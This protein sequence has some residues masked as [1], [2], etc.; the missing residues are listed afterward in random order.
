MCYNL[1]YKLIETWSKSIKLQISGH[2]TG[3][4]K[5]LNVLRTH[6]IKELFAYKR[7]EGSVLN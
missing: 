2:L 3:L 7:I 1:L 5:V 6:D 4:L